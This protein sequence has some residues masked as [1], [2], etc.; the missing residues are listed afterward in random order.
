MRLTLGGKKCSQGQ[1][2]DCA[3]AR[4][5]LNSYHFI[6][7]VESYDQSVGLQDTS[8]SNDKFQE[9]AAKWVGQ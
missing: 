7:I 6:V 4:L 9:Q 8:R 5:D 2:C 3:N 1:T